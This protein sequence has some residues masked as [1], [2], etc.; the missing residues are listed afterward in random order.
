MD[1]TSS[2]PHHLIKLTYLLNLCKFRLKSSLLSM[3]YS[4]YTSS[5][6]QQNKLYIH[7]YP[8]LAL[9]L[10]KKSWK[11]MTL[12]PAKTFLHEKLHICTN[13]HGDWSKGSPLRTNRQLN[14]IFSSNK[15]RC[16]IQTKH[17]RFHF[18][19]MGHLYF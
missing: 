3:I 16:C 8:Y 14:I 5:R 17:F 15:F 7:Y 12:N 11:S 18:S 6:L 13:F 2:P 19:R 1:K 9:I 10:S 4:L